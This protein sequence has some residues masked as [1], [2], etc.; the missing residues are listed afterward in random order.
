MGDR[1][2]AYWVLVGTPE[3]KRPLGRPRR[4]L[5]DNIKMDLQELGW[6][7]MDWIDVAQDK[8]TRRAHVNA[9]MNLRVKQNAGNS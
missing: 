4:T 2:G 9:V 7:A 5:E 3:G 8:D 1:R 6:G